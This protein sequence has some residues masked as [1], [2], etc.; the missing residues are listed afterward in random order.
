MS[1]EEDASGIVKTLILSETNSLMQESSL[2]NESVWS[3][4]HDFAPSTP[5]RIPSHISLVVSL[6]GTNSVVSHFQTSSLLA[7]RPHLLPSRKDIAC[8]NWL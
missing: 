8:M 1:I 5:V 4:G 3:T 2:S 7:I 6:S